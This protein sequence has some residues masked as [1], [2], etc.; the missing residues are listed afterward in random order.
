MNNKI[1]LIAFL[2]ACFCASSI[3]MAVAEEDPIPDWNQE[4]L[5]GDWNGTRS[6]WFRNGADLRFTHKSD[7]L[8]NVS[9][10]L[11]RGTAW[12]GHTEARLEL[13]LEKLLG[14]DSTTAYVHYHSDLGSK[15]NRDYVGSHAGVD[16][17]EVATNTAQFYQ[18][19]IQRNW[20]EDR[21]SV[22]A[23]LYATDSEFNVTDSSGLFLSPPYGVS[24]EIAQT[25]Q[26][27]PPIFPTGALAVR[28]KY[29]TA[30]QQFYVMGAVTDG[31]PG[32][33]K[34]PRGTHIKLGDGDG[35]LSI[36]EFGY[37]PQPSAAE[38]A[39]PEGQEESEIFNKTAI[40]F[41]R[42]SSPFD[43]VDPTA[44]K[45]HRS[46]GMYFIAERTLYQE[47]DH[48]SQG[49]SSFIRFG[50][51]SEHTNHLDWTTSLGLRY[52]GL[53]AERGEDI[54]GVAVTVNHAGDR[55][56]RANSGDAS[57]I[58]WEM[59]YRAQIRPWLALQPTV[60]YIVNPDMNPAVKNA[61]VVGFRTE[62][63]F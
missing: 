15:F 22:L 2:T 5:T 33:P 24:N 44:T 54:A 12:L 25:G 43:D 21:I 31:V 13:D 4:T 63:D 60:Q 20:L 23:G 17:I 57:E 10:G 30:D 3:A 53:I 36:V 1:I 56:R 8:S 16:N 51:A 37:T 46:Q 38:A 61:S 47:H 52:R 18:A 11:K 59:T 14:W 49:L 45:K 6:S 39:K 58:G 7:V 29:T 34:N 19:W 50:T 26:N 55:Y 41:W 42:Y 28:V 27:G 62:I 9:G 40:G 32:D 48:P 35:T